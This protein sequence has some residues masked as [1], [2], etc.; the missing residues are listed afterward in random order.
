MLSSEFFHVVKDVQMPVAHCTADE[1]PLAA[2]VVVLPPPPPH[3]ATERTSTTTAA[4]PRRRDPRFAVGL[5]PI[6]CIASA[7]AS[8]HQGARTSPLGRR[9]SLLGRACRARPHYLARRSAEASHHRE[10]DPVRAEAESGDGRV[11]REALRHPLV[12]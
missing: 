9:A 11:L 12:A 1:P 8:D 3:A 7:G 4:P 6:T 10:A 5:D 2:L